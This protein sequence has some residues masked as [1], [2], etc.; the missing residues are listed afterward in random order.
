MNSRDLDDDVEGVAAAHLVLLQHLDAL[1]ET[2]ELDPAA[3]SL[4]PD[5]SVGHVLTH[6]ARNADG[7]RGMI[8][9][10][11][12]GEQAL[13][14]PGGLVQRTNDIEQ[15]ASRDAET[16]VADVRMTIWK[17]DAAW[18]TLD[19]D[20]WAGSGAMLTGEVVP[21]VVV[22]FRRWREV[23]V[24]HVDLGVPGF[25]VDDWSDAYVAKELAIQMRQWKSRRPMGMTDL[26]QAVNGLSAKR[27][28]AWLLSRLVVDG[29]EAPGPWS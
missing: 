14:Y 22:P 7:L 9:A 23:E 1:L 12:R 10:A 20:G 29:V 13:M 24:H 2:G 11:S 15:G 5:W 6:F 19:A 16:L 25:G 21:I 3:P 8:E 4:L 17:L 26:P 18:V 28:L 27:R